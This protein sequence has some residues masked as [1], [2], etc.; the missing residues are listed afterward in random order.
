[1]GRLHIAATMQTLQHDGADIRYAVVRFRGLHRSPI[2]QP[3]LRWF[4][5]SNFRDSR[6]VGLSV[7]QQPRN[8]AM[9]VLVLGLN[10][11]TSEC[12]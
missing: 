12:K 11:I 2:R 7:G 4:N 3:R 9:V 8:R 6:P 1:M 5:V 10:V